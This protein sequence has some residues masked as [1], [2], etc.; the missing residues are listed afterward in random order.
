M[1]QTVLASS[2]SLRVAEISQGAGQQAVQCL[3]TLMCKLQQTAP[4]CVKEGLR[5]RHAAAGVQHVH[6]R[7]SVLRLYLHR[8]VHLRSTED[9]PAAQPLA[10]EWQQLWGCAAA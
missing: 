8:R 7:A 10:C 5:N 4:G 2:L 6:H 9:W 3:C 1:N